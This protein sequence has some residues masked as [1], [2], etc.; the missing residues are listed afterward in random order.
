MWLSE[1]ADAP[2]AGT[3]AVRSRPAWASRLL[4]LAAG[5]AALTGV[6][7]AL[8]W[9]WRNPLITGWDYLSHVDTTLADAALVRAHDW[10]AVRD[11][12]FL[13]DRWEPPGLRL[14]GLPIALAFGHGALT[15]LRLSATAAFLLTAAVQFAALRRIA[16]V[17][18][19]AASVLVFT[20]AP[21]NITGAQNFMTEEVLTVAAAVALATLA[22]ELVS[23]RPAPSGAGLARLLLLGVALGWG[24]L[25]K[26]TLLPTLGMVWLGVVAI[27]WH[28]SRD[29]GAMLLRLLVPGAVLLLIAWPS[30]ALNGP[31]YLAYARASAGGFGFPIWPEHG[32]AFALRAAGSLVGDVFGPAGLLV[33]LLGLLLFL[34]RWRDVAAPLRAFGVLCLLASLPALAAFCFSR[35]QTDRYV[36]L[37][38]LLLGVPAALGIGAALRAALPVGRAAAATIALAAAAQIAAAWAIAFGAPLEGPLL[39]GL[40]YAGARP[41][42]ACDYR[43]LA[44]LTAPRDG[45]VRIGVYGE[46]QAVNPY[47][48]TYGY[49]QAGVPARVLQFSNSSSDAVDWDPILAEAAQ[50]DYVILPEVVGGWYAGIIT[51][52]TRDQ[53]RARLAAVA[54]VTP[55][56]EVA[57]GPEPECRVQ[58]LEVRPAPGAPPPRRPP[59]RPE[60]FIPGWSAGL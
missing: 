27:L 59:L 36:V 51:N 21:V 6:G 60:T 49:R 7:L 37:D 56:G 47:D 16:G 30:Y 54:A 41:N 48:V 11:Q 42:Y 10:G 35:N 17:G 2:A 33:L 34:L 58:V 28:R 13:L 14:L 12:F 1:T 23:Q 39:S 46:S 20:L 18:G 45:P 26:L 19:A 24:T 57:T 25:T 9:L 55:L 31:R 38:T 29:A 5:A 53:F 52:R 15:A 32:A 4:R 43:V 22:S 44:R 50:T 3:G 8:L 40:V